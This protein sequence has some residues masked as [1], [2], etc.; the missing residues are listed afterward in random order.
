[1][2][3]P[4]QGRA[5]ISESYDGIVITIPAKKN[6]FVMVFSCAWL[7]S[8][9]CFAIFVCT[10][11]RGPEGAAARPFIFGF[12]SLFLIPWISALRK[13]WWNIAG[14][15]IVRVFSGLLTIDRSD[16]L[17][18]RIKSYDLS[19]CTNFRAV[20]QE[21]PI[22]HY[23]GR[24]VAMLRRRPNPG[25]IRFE[26]DVVDTVQ[27]GDWLSEAEGNYILDRIRAKKLIK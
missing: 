12:L 22:Y 9:S 23:Y 15:E 1:M 3:I 14:K 8:F 24:T 26:Y 6:L 17:F 10:L 13:L 21:T 2:E 25:T 5:I 19:L 4:Y 27:F 7:I 20:E 11:V 16:D 18:K